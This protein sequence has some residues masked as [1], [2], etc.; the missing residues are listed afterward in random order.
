MRD[1]KKALAFDGIR[2]IAHIIADT[3][4]RLEARLIKLSNE[5]S[6]ETVHADM[7]LLVHDIWSIIDNTR[8]LLPLF[9]IV[10]LKINDVRHIKILA[11]IKE[12]RDS[13]HHLE[14]RIKL[15]FKDNGDSLF[16]QIYWQSREDG[17]E[18]AITHI[19]R[20]GI[21]LGP[22]QVTEQPVKLY[23][24]GTRFANALG[25]FNLNLVYVIK[26]TF[27]KK[28]REMTFK[29][30][31]V[32][33]DNLIDFLKITFPIIESSVIQATATAALENNIQIKDMQQGEGPALMSISPKD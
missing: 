16:G 30:I 4:G 9:E 15:Y 11:D 18:R 32:N 27:N 7:A 22:S 14:E 3:S 33:I 8:R 2:H 20:S 23:I 29:R 13:F 5:P 17:Q 10:G 25:V 28:T 26:E 19:A 31:E 12:L 6:D 1:T 21:L 24:K